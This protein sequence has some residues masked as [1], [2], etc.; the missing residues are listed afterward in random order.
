MTEV[1]SEMPNNYQYLEPQ[2]LEAMVKKQF[3]TE[4]IHVGR[5]RDAGF[6]DSSDVRSSSVSKVQLDNYRLIDLDGDEY[7]DDVI[8]QVKVWIKYEKPGKYWGYR[9]TEVSFN[10]LFVTSHS[11]REGESHFEVRLV[12]QKG[13]PIPS[14]LYSNTSSGLS[15]HPEVEDLVS[16]PS[17][18]IG[19]LRGE[20]PSVPAQAEEILF[21][22]ITAENGDPLILGFQELF[23]GH[24]FYAG[25]I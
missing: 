20:T 13:E 23:V 1:K 24:W 25:D 5:Y 6:Y 15:N 18:R 16:V 11:L 3:D 7:T 10:C 21:P 17:Y 8:G 22:F 14:S 19:N 2:N 4:G 9:E 12:N